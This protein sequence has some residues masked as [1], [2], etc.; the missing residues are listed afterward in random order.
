MTFERSQLLSGSGIPDE[1]DAV[2][3]SGDDET[4]IRTVGGRSNVLGMALQVGGLLVSRLVPGGAG[5]L[6]G[7][8]AKGGRGY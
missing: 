1:G 2:E 4:A 7:M 3:A 6:L 8:G 5:S